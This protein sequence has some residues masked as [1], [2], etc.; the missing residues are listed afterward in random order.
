MYFNI[1][2]SMS[3]LKEKIRLWYWAIDDRFY[4]LYAWFGRILGYLRGPAPPRSLMRITS[5]RSV[6]GFR[7]SGLRTATPIETACKAVGFHFKSN[8]RILDFGCGCGRQ[9]A[10]F[11]QWHPACRFT[12]C[13]VNRHAVDYI[14]RMC[15]VAEAVHNAFRPPLS[16]ENESFDLIYTVSTFSHFSESDARE[17]MRELHRV[18]KSDGFLALTVE[19]PSVLDRELAGVL[20][21]EAHEIL[22]RDG[23]YYKEYANLETA[24][25]AGAYSG[26]SMYPGIDDSYGNTVITEQYMD[27]HWIPI[28]FERLLTLERVIGGR[29]DLIVMRKRSRQDPHS[30]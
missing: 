10:L 17:W 1:L 2:L 25:L 7:E 23:I 11:M 21:E 29:Q 4:G 19:G 26:R 14:R 15:P 5:A 16:F 9:L 22:V 3:V 13:D 28:G 30:R 6:T 27:A 24:R 18:L 12:A 8:A 20:D